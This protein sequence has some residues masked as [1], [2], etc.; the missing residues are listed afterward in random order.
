M[1]SRPRPP[2]AS[3][4]AGS[5]LDSTAELPVLDV[6][7]PAASATTT[8]AK[9]PA[10]GTEDPLAATDS[11]A[12]SPAARAALSAAA[13]TAEEQRQQQ[14]EL[15]SR[16]NALKEA[17]ERL[18]S[19]AKRLLQLE[20]A[21]DEALASQA[22]AAQ[23][24]ASAEQRAASAEQRAASAEQRTASVEQRLAEL[25]QRAAKLRTELAQ[26]Q[27]AATQNAARLEESA[28]ALAAAEQRAAAASEELA[29]ARALVSA[30]G[31]RA[32]EL[33]QRLE[34]EQ[35]ES[36]ALA[37]RT[38]EREQQ[39]ALSAAGRVH[40]AGMME[41]LHNERAR[42]MTYLES[43]QTL[44]RR[45]EISQHLVTDL[46]HEAEAR[47][48]E[49]VRLTSEL[50][51]S[52]ERVLRQEEALTQGAARI[53]QLEQQ[54][55]TLTTMVTQRDAQ[56]QDH[57]EEAQGLRTSVARLQTEIHAGA[58]RVR[59]LEEQSAQ[60]DSSDTQQQDE[61]QRLLSEIAGLNGVVEAARRT[62]LAA[63]AQ[64][65]SQQVVLV[66]HTERAAELSATL[67][68]ERK[69]A[70]QLEIELATVRGEMDEWA[71]VL[72]SAQQARSG[73]LASIAAAESRVRELEHAAA[74]REERVRALEH[75]AAAREE[76][77]RA[78]EA[79]CAA[80]GARRR[81]LENELHAAEEVAQRLEADTRT[82][83]ARI[84]EL[85]RSGEARQAATDTNPAPRQLV[86]AAEESSGAEPVPDGATRLLIHSAD[87]REVVHV[88]G[89]KTSIGRTPDNDLQLDAKF[90]SRHHAVIL[91]GPAGAVIEDLNSTN[92]VQVNGRRVTRQTLRDGD[93]IAIGR[94]H[95]RFAVRKA[96][97][98]R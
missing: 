78:L 67:E 61:L 6:A 56:L 91:A 90:V 49:V 16:T 21:R 33:Q 80:H 68:A 27:G 47:A 32:Q 3:S 34:Q 13:A 89:R 20:Q 41:D 54:A 37:Q 46:H 24:A 74:A 4:H 84:T 35:Q 26:R 97:D 29:R 70:T 40:A 81:Q 87:G 83:A 10:A 8:T 15:R 43:L 59:A 82:R 5:D 94:M 14:L 60:R 23:R 9:F 44:E 52:G 98:K 19:H 92:G 72:R 95:Y 73:H 31:A 93:Q 69:R 28:R 25:E 71:S 17:E 38:R 18:A 45:R 12:L 30:S 2:P 63:T 51:A 57:H 86:H 79:E 75:A 11:W 1:S 42:A 64:A 62:T 7:A 96:A 48:A 39:Q 50:A 76:R 58:E 53:A 22:A 55:S 77:V 36:D 85:E 65:S 66:Q 88:L